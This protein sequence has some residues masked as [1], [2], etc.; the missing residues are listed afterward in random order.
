MKRTQQARNRGENEGF[1]APAARIKG[2]GGVPAALM[3]GSPAVTPAPA[4][5]SRSARN[6]SDSSWVFSKQIVVRHILS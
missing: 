4:T 1:C 5:P 3:S 2:G 6:S